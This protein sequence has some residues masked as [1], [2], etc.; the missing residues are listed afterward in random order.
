MTFLGLMRSKGNNSFFLL[1][2]VGK[3]LNSSLLTKVLIKAID[4]P[5]PELKIV[6]SRSFAPSI[7]Y[8]PKYSLSRRL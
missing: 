5:P 1:S 2:H 4:Y 7:Q 6:N 8:C 3:N